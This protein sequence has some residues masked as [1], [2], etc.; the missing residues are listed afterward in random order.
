M[1]KETLCSSE[2]SAD[3]DG[4]TR[5]LAPHEVNTSTSGE[6]ERHIVLSAMKSHGDILLNIF[7]SIET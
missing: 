4:N 3:F 7:K 2:T 5:D 6:M 1:K